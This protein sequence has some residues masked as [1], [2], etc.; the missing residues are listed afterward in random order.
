M[1]LTTLDWNIR[2][3]LQSETRMAGTVRGT[4]KG[5]GATCR[6]RESLVL[7]HGG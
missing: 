2:L 6:I 3:D 5:L 7:T 1:C 4:A